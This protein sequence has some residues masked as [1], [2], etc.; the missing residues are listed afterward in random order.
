MKAHEGEEIVCKCAQPAGN[1][2]HNVEDHASISSDD[3]AISPD[4]PVPDDDDRVVCPTCKTLMAQRL[5]G[6]RWGVM[7]RNGWLE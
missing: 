3:I 4:L 5:S 2:R 7:T 1:F 6:D